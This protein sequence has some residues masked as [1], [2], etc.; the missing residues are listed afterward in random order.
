MDAPTRFFLAAIAVIVLVTAGKDAFLGILQVIGAERFAVKAVVKGLL[1]TLG[2]QPFAVDL[3]FSMVVG[4]G[5]ILLLWAVVAK[6][7]RAV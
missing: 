1:E 7:L 5:T 6:L 4:L 2:V 3:A